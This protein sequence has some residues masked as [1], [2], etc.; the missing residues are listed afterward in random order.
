[1]VEVTNTATV[2]ACFVYGSL[3][4]DDDSGQMWTKEA[5]KGMTARKAIVKGVGLYQHHYAAAI[6]GKEGK[7]VVGF[8]LTHDD[9]K[10]FKEKLQNYDRIEGY[11]AQNPA[12]GLYQRDEVEAIIVDDEGKETEEKVR[13]WM[14]HRNGIPENDEV[15]EGDWLK[16]KY[17]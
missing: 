12:K 8:V 16:R 3:R 2:Q 5:C 9:N 1:M 15:P 17:K 7:Q 6:F 11:N 13:T 4:P 10:V 14:Y